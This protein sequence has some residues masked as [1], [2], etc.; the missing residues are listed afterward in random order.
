MKHIRE[1]ITRRGYAR[2]GLIGNPSDGYFGKT[3]SILIKNYFAEIVLTE[4]RE[5]E[6]LLTPKDHTTFKSIAALAEDVKFY[7]YYGGIRLIKAAIKRFHDHVTAEGI[8]IPDWNFTIKYRTDIPIMVGMAGSSAI[9]TATMRALTRF[10]N[11]T[12]PDEVLPTLILEVETKELKIPAGLQDRVIQVYGGCC[13]MDFN[14]EHMQ[15]YGHGRYVK[16]DIR[17]LPPLYVAYRADLSEGTEVF[18]SDIRERFNRGDPTVVAAMR[19]WADITDRFRR[20]METGDRAGM[21]ALI[22]RNFDL[23]ASIYNISKDNWEMVNLARNVGA[24]AKFAGSGGAIVGSYADARMF[25]NLE[26]AFRP[27]GIKVIKPDIR[28]FNAQHM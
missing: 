26:E 1:V 12:I 24:S 16:L 10:Y 3:I 8:H 7:G 15:E 9:I 2:A 21:N 28:G 4:S 13:Y 11:V 20:A 22:N 23:R 5:L 14:Y 27:A 25:R 19:E 17:K 6:I 18:H